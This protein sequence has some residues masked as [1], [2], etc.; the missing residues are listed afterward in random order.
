MIGD[1]FSSSPAANGS[2]MIARVESLRFISSSLFVGK[3]RTFS[4]NIAHVVLKMNKTGNTKTSFL[5]WK[6]ST[7]AA[8]K[9]LNR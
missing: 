2:R 6:Q 9:N 8:I 5:W 1:K 7:F 3:N 4:L